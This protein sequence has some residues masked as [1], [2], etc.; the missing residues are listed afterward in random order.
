MDPLAQTFGSS[1]GCLDLLWHK[2]WI[3]SV[4]VSDL[5]D[6]V[7][8]NVVLRVGSRKDTANKA[9]YKET[10]CIGPVLLLQYR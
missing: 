8:R 10:H 7:W 6:Y 3:G 2:L 5:L 1:G 4:N 9:T